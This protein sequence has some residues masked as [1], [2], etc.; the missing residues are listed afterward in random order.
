[1]PKTMTI[2]PKVHELA[3]FWL[4]ADDTASAKDRKPHDAR[5]L[6]LA[7]DI[8][9]A[10]EDWCEAEAEYYAQLSEHHA[11]MRATGGRSI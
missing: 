3:E 8:Q 11:E 2:D 6:S 10:I 5:V 7:S 4:S 9:R 1:M